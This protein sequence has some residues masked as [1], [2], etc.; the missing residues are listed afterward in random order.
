MEP[1]HSKKKDGDYQR[2]SKNVMKN[3][4]H[5]TRYC[6]ACKTTWNRDFNAARNM[7]LIAMYMANNDLKRPLPFKDEHTLSADQGP[8]ASYRR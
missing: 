7:A 3:K 4:I 2:D 8:P 6:K 1:G 5:G